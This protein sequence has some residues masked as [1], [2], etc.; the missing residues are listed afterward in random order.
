MGK[1]KALAHHT[2]TYFHTRRVS[3]AVGN[4]LPPQKKKPLQLLT[5]SNTPPFP[6]WLY[7]LQDIHDILMHSVPNREI[8]SYSERMYSFRAQIELPRPSP[9]PP[10]PGSLLV[11]PRPPRPEDLRPPLTGY[12]TYRI[13]LITGCISFHSCQILSLKNG[14][15]GFRAQTD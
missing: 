4:P 8:H 2:S 5:P 3:K 13:H 10:S 9:V 14:F 11:E 15:Y 1:N 6:H 7:D 12:T